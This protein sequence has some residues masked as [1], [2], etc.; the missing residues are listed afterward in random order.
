MNAS[1]HTNRCCRTAGFSMVEA[2]IVIAIIGILSAL[3]VPQMGGIL[4]G[5]RKSVAQ[6]LLDSLNKAT[7]EFGHAYWSLRTTPDTATGNDELTILRTLQWRESDTAAGGELHTKGPFMRPDWSPLTS[8]ST[9]DY[10]LVW[11][12]S[13]WRLVQPT[14]AGAGLKINFNASDLGTTYTYP[15]NYKPV[16]QN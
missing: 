2:L 4:N 16:G 13:S 3:A 7:R 11:T 12:G 8:T 5:S 14:Q 10:R 9:T 1:Q 15:A 6:N